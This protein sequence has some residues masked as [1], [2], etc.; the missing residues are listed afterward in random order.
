VAP[1]CSPRIGDGNDETAAIVADTTAAMTETDDEAMADAAAEAAVAEETAAAMEPA[2][3]E[4][5][6]AQEAGK[7]T[8]T[9]NGAL[10]VMEVVM[11]EAAIEWDNEPETD[12]VDPATPQTP[13]V[14]ARARR[15]LV[16]ARGDRLQRDRDEAGESLRCTC[17]D[18]K[19]IVALLMK[20]PP[21]RIGADIVMNSVATGRAIVIDAAV[22]DAL[23][24]PLHE[25]RRRRRRR[26]RRGRTRLPDEQPKAAPK[27]KAKAPPKPR[28]KAADSSDDEG[29]DSD[30]DCDGGDDDDDMAWSNGKDT[31][32]P[33]TTRGSRWPSGWSAAQRA[34][35]RR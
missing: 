27:A 4:V 1:A 12:M 31:R 5:A 10:P 8:P 21:V 16:P 20:P 9:G 30:G 11:A 32:T 6:E 35:E 3:E 17:E 26:R 29:S 2:A 34:R 7:A 14:P 18:W 13:I 33:P 25:S 24:A 22:E 15:P 19:R 23:A 28:K